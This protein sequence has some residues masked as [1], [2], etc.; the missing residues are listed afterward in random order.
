MCHDFKLM[1]WVDNLVFDRL[2]DEEL[3][4]FIVDSHRASRSVQSNM[5][6]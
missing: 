5:A 1:I 2:I 3:A 6:A 4:K